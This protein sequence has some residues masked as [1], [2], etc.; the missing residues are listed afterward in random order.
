[1]HDLAVDSGNRIL[2][3][4]NESDAVSRQMHF[5][6]FTQEGMPDQSFSATGGHLSLEPV[7]HDTLLQAPPVYNTSWT[8]DNK[9][10]FVLEYRYNKT[11]RGHT[12]I[13][14]YGLAAK[15]EM[16]TGIAAAKSVD[17]AIYPQPA[18]K[19]LYIRTSGARLAALTIVNAAG[20]TVMERQSVGED[21]L[22][23]DIQSLAPGLY[24]LR[25]R[26]MAGSLIN[27]PVIIVR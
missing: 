3:S 2:L 15:K 18:D 21:H 26:D 20:Q 8:A 11:Y 27:R 13:F 10:F 19:V 23:L 6:C 16:Q 7:L 12:G 17:V 4:W 5:S 14:K 1:M 24:I 9:H 25:L 22:S